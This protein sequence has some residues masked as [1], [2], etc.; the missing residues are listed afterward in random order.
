MIIFIIIKLSTNITINTYQL[1]KDSYEFIVRNP[2]IT[3]M[4]FPAQ[5]VLKF[6]TWS[7]FSST[8][9]KALPGHS[10]CQKSDDARLD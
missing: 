4:I 7:I 3:K 1:S 8:L 9:F 2:L 6:V 10:G 5:E